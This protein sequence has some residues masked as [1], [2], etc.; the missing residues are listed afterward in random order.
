MALSIEP[1]KAV[2]GA[3]VTNVSLGEVPSDGVVAEI[4]AA[5]EQ[6]GVLIFPDQDITPGQQ[7]AFSAAF[8]PLEVPSLLHARVPEHPEVFIVGNTQEKPVTFSPAKPEGELEWHT[9]HIHKAVTARAS[10]LYAM[11]VPSV[12]GDTAFACMYSAHDALTAQQQADYARLE[13]VNS[14]AGLRAYLNGQGYD[15]KKQDRHGD[16]AEKAIWPLVRAHP[17]TGRRALYFGAKVSIG[18]V[19][20]EEPAAL[21]FVRDLTA[22]AC[23]PAF[24]YRHKWS[25]GDAVLWDN[26]RMLHAGTHYEIERDTRLMHRTTWR[27]TE[28]IEVLG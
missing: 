15:S 12:G 9:D 7:V 3:R 27:E 18:V 5:L 20:W 4:E 21:D 6:Y 13:M 17:L 23:R 28:A 14:V 8:A 25:V 19:G 10:L 1:T 16:P 22:H 26:R 2:I 11:V 24:Q